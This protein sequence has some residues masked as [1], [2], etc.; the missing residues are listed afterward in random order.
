MTSYKPRIKQLFQELVSISD[1]DWNY[2]SERL[3]FKQFGKKEK[4]TQAG[5]V[6]DN[7][8][9]LADGVVRFVI[10][11]D[12]KESTT[13]FSFTGQFFCSYSSFIT[14]QPSIFEI[15]PVTKTA[16]C[17]YI[18]WNDLQQVYA[19]TSC[20]EEIGRMAAE[21]QFIRK[22]AREV[23]LLTIHPKD[24]YLQLLDEQP[25]WVH[26]I[27]LKHLA[28]YMGITPETLSRIRSSIMNSDS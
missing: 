11:N 19:N 21:Q 6:E 3:Q 7:L 28:S 2:F 9:F 8:Y 26:Q 14:R 15:R 20:G 25:Q 27:P 1:S 16:S 4:I 10:Q 23:S 5:R 12:N 24:R 13:D 18:T 22:S 17:C